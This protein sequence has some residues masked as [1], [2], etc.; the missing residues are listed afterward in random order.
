MIS[1]KMLKDALISAALTLSDMKKQVD[2]LNVYPVPDGDT[3]TNMS[4]TLTNAM[5]AL[6]NLDD[7][8]AVSEVASVAAS[9][10]LRGARGN[11]GVITSLL[12]RGFSKGLADKKEADCD[13]MANALSSPLQESAQKRQGNPPLS[14][15]T[16]W[17]SGRTCV[18]PQGMLWIKLPSSSQYL[19]KPAL[20]TQAERVSLSSL[21][22]CSVPLR[23]SQEPL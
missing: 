20:L 2:E 16:L 14:Q 3:G 21:K 23:A 19:K 12:F 15:T 5:N 17:Y 1:G 11:S 13:D 10:M 7:G 6:Q 22:R 18:L 9:A 4:L 8:A